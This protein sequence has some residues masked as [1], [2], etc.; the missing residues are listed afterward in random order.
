MGPTP[1]VNQ[2]WLGQVSPFRVQTNQPG[3]NFLHGTHMA[4]TAN[5]F[6]AN[7]INGSPH[8]KIYSNFWGIEQIDIEK[9]QGQMAKMIAIW[10]FYG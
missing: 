1:K 8:L 6:N 5:T 9:K 10:A 3:R 4:Q 7:C 2:D